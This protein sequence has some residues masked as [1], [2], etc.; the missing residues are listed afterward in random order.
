M[1]RIRS[2]PDLGRRLHWFDDAHDEVLA[3]LYR[4]AAAVLVPSHSEGFG[5][6]A[7]EALGHGTPVVASSGGALPEVLSDVPAG[8]VRFAD[9]SSPQAWATA[10]EE[11]TADPDTLAAARAAAAAFTPRTWGE[12]A[13]GFAGALL[14]AAQR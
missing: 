10:V 6:P 5:L 11:L 9:P 2:H 8:A 12:S 1:A 14:R 4:G 3:T 7:L 13:E